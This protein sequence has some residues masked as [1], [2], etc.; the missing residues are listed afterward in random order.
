MKEQ[1][2]EEID[3]QRQSHSEM[4]QL[5]EEKSDELQVEIRA[6]MERLSDPSTVMSVYLEKDLPALSQTLEESIQDR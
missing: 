3:S 5:V 1:I 4:R 2:G 6:E